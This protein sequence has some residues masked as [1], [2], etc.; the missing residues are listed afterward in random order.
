MYCFSR[1]TPGVILLEHWNLVTVQILVCA[2]CGRSLLAE[3]AALLRGPPDGGLAEPLELGVELPLGVELALLRRILGVGRERELFAESRHLG[4]QGIG[5]PLRLLDQAGPPE[6]LDQVA[7]ATGGHAPA[8][9]DVQ[10]EGTEGLHDGCADLL[11]AAADTRVGVEQPQ[12]SVGGGTATQHGVRGAVGPGVALVGGGG[13]LLTTDQ[14]AEERLDDQRLVDLDQRPEP[15][16]LEGGDGEFIRRAVELTLPG[17]HT[18]DGAEQDAR[19]HDEDVHLTVRHNLE[20]QLVAGELL[21]HHGVALEGLGPAHEDARHNRPTATRRVE[22]QVRPT[23]EDLGD[24]LVDHGVAGEQ[25]ARGDLN[26][27]GVQQ[28]LDIR[29]DVDAVGLL[30]GVDGR[31]HRLEGRDRRT[32]DAV[33]TVGLGNHRLRDGNIDHVL[34]EAAD[35]VERAH[36]P[37]DDPLHVGDVT[38]PTA[39][40][41][42][43]GRDDRPHPAGDDLVGTGVDPADEGVPLRRQHPR[44]RGLGVG[45][46]PADDVGG[47]VEGARRRGLVHRA[48][49]PGRAPGHGLPRLALGLPRLLHGA[50][51]PAQRR[52]DLTAVRRDGLL[53]PLEG[54]AELGAEVG[55]VLPVV[56]IDEAAHGGRDVGVLPG[57]EGLDRVAVVTHRP[58]H[59]VEHAAGGRA[60]GGLDVLRVEVDV[61]LGD[62]DADEA[63]ADQ[64]FRQAGDVTATQRGGA[65]TGLVLGAEPTDHGGERPAHAGEARDAGA[66]ENPAVHQAL[67]VVL[68]KA[69]ATRELAEGERHQLVGQRRHLRGRGSGQAEEGLRHLPTPEGAEGIRGVRQPELVGGDAHR[70]SVGVPE[71]GVDVHQLVDERLPD[72]RVGVEGEVGGHRL[73]RGG[74]GD[75]AG[76]GPPGDAQDRVEVPRRDGDGEVTATAIGDPEAGAVTLGGVELPEGPHGVPLDDR[77]E[78]RDGAVAVRQHDDDADLQPHL[79]RVVVLVEH[80][81]D[82]G[83]DEPHVRGAAA[84]GGTRGDVHHQHAVVDTRLL[85]HLVDG[86]LDGG[87]D[88]DRVGEAGR[89]ADDALLGRTRGDGRGQVHREDPVE[90]VRVLTPPILQVLPGE[91]HHLDLL[92]LDVHRT[93]G[94]ELVVHAVEVD[95]GVVGVDDDRAEVA[96][97][98]ALQL[99]VGREHRGGAEAAEAD[100]QAGVR[101]GLVGAGGGGGG[102][103]GGRHGGS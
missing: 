20:A 38:I 39:R 69:R 58:I 48:A 67:H 95:A 53:Q 42:A 12:V 1:H 5:E 97:L 96:E 29:E 8:I 66:A 41:V 85:P 21:L 34:E 65:A 64:A 74:G 99:V 2:E 35:A 13:H 28:S 33:E 94:H 75:V 19:H 40:G 51:E 102:G 14:R 54:G 55:H 52:A 17:L 50:G 27:G 88:L 93:L 76:G 47:V 100:E 46:G 87:A 44:E 45:V 22:R 18:A 15:Q 77:A 4:Q 89:G 30:P 84:A 6:R 78:L 24:L 57:E 63:E 73:Q 98:L 62:G 26:G 81:V 37:A 79:A 83:G 82:E 7:Q 91:A 16:A 92:I 103:T 23:A 49:Q 43:G 3:R 101:E 56:Q 31:Q 80:V 25:L 60:P 61:G 68:G 86:R 59:L 71:V 72:D 36:Q 11:G 70:L 9:T 90:D 10:L 32:D